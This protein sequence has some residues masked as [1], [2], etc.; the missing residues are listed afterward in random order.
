MILYINQRRRRYSCKS[1]RLLSWK[2]IGAVVLREMTLCCRDWHGQGR[3]TRPLGACL[4]RRALCCSGTRSLRG[5]RQGGAQGFHADHLGGQCGDA[6][7]WISS[8]R[9]P[10]FKSRG[11]FLRSTGADG[12][13][14]MALSTRSSSCQPMNW[15]SQFLARFTGMR[16]EVPWAGMCR[17]SSPFRILILLLL[18]V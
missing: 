14:S 16:A 10:R 18:G 13:C 5:I 9:S 7:G 3:N 4:C 2:T 15:S 6:D 1:M 17:G 12:V 11:R 8:Y